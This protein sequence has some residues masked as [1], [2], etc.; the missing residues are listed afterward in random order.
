MGD[1][2]SALEEHSGKIMVGLI[3]ALGA[4]LISV[5]DMVLR[6]DHAIGELV[7]FANTGDRFTGRDGDRLERRVSIIEREHREDIDG[8]SARDSRNEQTLHALLSRVAVLEARLS[9]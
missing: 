8:I 5:R 1:W 2:K 4:H 9:Q 6:H 7:E 3:M